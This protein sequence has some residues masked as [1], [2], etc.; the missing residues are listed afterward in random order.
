MQLCGSNKII[1]FSVHILLDMEEQEKIEN[2]IL[3]ENAY[4]YKKVFAKYLNRMTVNR[5]FS[6][7][8]EEKFGNYL[9]EKKKEPII[10]GNSKVELSIGVFKYRRKPSFIKEE[11]GGWDEVKLA[12]LVLI[13]FEDHL[14][15]AKRNV[16]DFKELKGKVLLV[17]YK[18]LSSLFIDESTTFEKFSMHNLDISDNAVRSKS[19]EATDLKQSLSA[20]GLNNYVLSNLRIATNEDKVSLSL[21]SSRINKFGNK[22]DIDYIINWAYLIVEKIRNFNVVENFIDVF[23][24]PVD[25]QSEHDKLKP[26]ALL[27]IL[28]KLYDEFEANRIESCYI[29]FGDSIREIN[30][31]RH[32]S[33]FTRLQTISQVVSDKGIISYGVNTSVTDDLQLFINQKSITL[34]SE[35]LKSVRLKFVDDTELSILDFFNKTS[36]FIINFDEVELVYTHR[37]LFRD[38]RLLGNIDHFLEVFQPYVELKDTLSEKG[39]PLN[40][41]QEFPNNSIFQFIEDKFLADSKYLICDDLGREWADYISIKEESIAFYHAKWKDS[42]FSASDLQDVIGQAQKNLGNIIPLD[43]QLDK[44]SEFWKKNYASTQIKRLRK[45]SDIDETVIE[46]KNLRFLPNL[47]KQVYIVINFISKNELKDRLQKLKKGENFKEKNEVIQILWFV[48]SL[49]SSCH[50]VNVETYIICQP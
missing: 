14:V 26:I 17:D 30:L 42:Q 1:K 5:I 31:L 43:N 38:N 37:K 50:E 32:I 27:F 21:G 29:D 41:S 7:A 44:K 12:Y 46:Y 24:I 49:I 48:S 23:S 8:S 28:T 19:L 15:V 47:R 16:S 4:F 34:R 40:T 20:I 11:V 25:F 22:N 18:T 45:G 9:L 6:E 10:I 3:N 2:L 35:K 36:S 33:K 13:D 39:V